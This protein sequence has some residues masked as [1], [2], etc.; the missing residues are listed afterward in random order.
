MFGSKVLV[1]KPDKKPAGKFDTGAEEGS[2][3]GPCQKRAYRVRPRDQRMMS[4]SRDA[5]LLESEIQ[6]VV[7]AEKPIECDLSSLKSATDD[8]DGCFAP[9]GHD[10]REKESLSA[11]K[12]DY[13][14]DSVAHYP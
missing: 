3:A 13:D 1:C 10:D 8:N 4:K 9:H 14:M 7:T 11:R 12:K 6:E 5:K 2:L